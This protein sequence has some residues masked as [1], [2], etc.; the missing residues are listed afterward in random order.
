[1]GMERSLIILRPF[2]M[3]LQSPQMLWNEDIFKQSLVDWYYLK[4]SWADYSMTYRPPFLPSSL[5]LRSSQYAQAS[6]SSTREYANYLGTLRACFTCVRVSDIDAIAPDKHLPFTGAAERTRWRP[7][8]HQPKG[9]SGLSRRSEGFLLFIATP[10]KFQ[11]HLYLVDPME[12][13][14]CWTSAF[15][16]QAQLP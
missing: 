2:D 6:Q 14:V 15:R 10:K 12:P 13:S 4:L 11:S 5:F 8:K 3:S 16:E 1:M 9:P 7:R